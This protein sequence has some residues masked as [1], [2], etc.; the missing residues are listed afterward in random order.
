MTCCNTIRIKILQCL[1]LAP[2]PQKTGLFFIFVEL[3]LNSSCSVFFHDNLLQPLP[4]RFMHQMCA[5]Y[6]SFF[7]GFVL[8]SGKP[9]CTDV[10]ILTKSG[11]LKRKLVT[12]AITLVHNIQ[13]GQKKVSHYREPSLNRIKNRY[14]G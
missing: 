12:S 10:R 5:W 6:K 9:W 4:W 14:P 1:P 11:Q 13:G 7:Y 8:T 2:S 3:I